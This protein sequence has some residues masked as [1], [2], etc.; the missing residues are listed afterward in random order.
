MLLQDS[1]RH[2]RQVY[3]HRA[4][5]VDGTRALTYVELDDRV[6]RLANALR[7]GLGLRFGERFAFLSPNRAEFLE[8]YFGAATAGLVCV[9][10][11]PRLASLEMV[12][13][14][15]DAEARALLADASLLAHIE[16][17]RAA[18]FAGQI[19]SLGNADD[20][21]NPY[22]QLL[23]GASASERRDPIDADD[24]AIQIYTSGTTGQPKG[25]M[26]T[27]RNLISNSWHLMS[28][29]AAMPG[30]RYL[31]IAP[32]CHL[33]AG[34]RVF[35]LVHACSTHVLHTSF[36][37]ERCVSALAAGEANS[38]LI[39][40]AML[41]QL[42]DAADTSGLSLRGMVRQITYGT[43]PMPSALLFEA[44]ERLG[45]DFQQG[46]GLTEAGPNLTIL[47]PEDHRPGQT[48]TPERLASVGRETRGVHVRVVDG[49]DAD[50]A[51]GQ[52]GEII[53]RGPNIMKG[54]WR[55]PDETA[56]A[57]RQGWLRTG[58]LATIDEHGYVT[59]VDRKKDMLVSG[60]FNVYPREI[61]R[62]LERH[63]A[64]A[65]VAVVGAA[66]E[67]WGEVPIA[68]VAPTSSATDN[69]ELKRQLTALCTKQLARY[70]Q[71]R[72][73]R[74]LD[75][76]PRNPVGKIAKRELR[77]HVQAEQQ[78]LLSRRS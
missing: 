24:T 15:E 16:E 78:T 54:Y 43:A 71:P 72:D 2:A 23:R 77:D 44:L 65:E 12:E 49:S 73:Y 17:I 3:P 76:L 19:V 9:P 35:L 7:D 46:Y 42:L 75:S 39:V 64:V 74:F 22:E 51:V 58:D 67:R 6:R 61:E 56:D 69:D 41:R 25:V 57:L 31:N 32:L 37:A 10:L 4:A 8:V 34:S 18:G 30:D 21:P 55:R 62:Q 53:A 45:C 48:G 14:L 63:P 33:G 1:L 5:V 13:I 68:F 52:V 20:E 28:E 38:A 36:D 26:L 47:P 11:N 50:V 60:G 70:K 59:I 66:H 29:G 40:P 27:H